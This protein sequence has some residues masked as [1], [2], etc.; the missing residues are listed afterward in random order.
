MKTFKEHLKEEKVQ[1]YAAVKQSGHWKMYVWD[2][3]GWDD[4]ASK[5][6]LYPTKEKLKRAIIN[7]TMGGKLYVKTTDG[8]SQLI[9]KWTDL[10]NLK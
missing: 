5:K 7:R 2:G 3:A 9:K 4:N 6:K 10:D 1:Y 8:D